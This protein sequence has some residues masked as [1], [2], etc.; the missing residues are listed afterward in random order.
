MKQMEDPEKVIVCHSCFEPYEENSITV[1]L[2]QPLSR[3]H[4]RCAQVL[5]LN[6]NTYD[7]AYET[8]FIKIVKYQGRFGQYGLQGQAVLFARDVTEVLDK[9]SRKPKSMDLVIL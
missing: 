4:S 7:L 5:N 3:W 8:D 1:F 6:G 9:L 2:E